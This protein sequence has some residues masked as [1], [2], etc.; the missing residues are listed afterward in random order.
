MNLCGGIQANSEYGF[1][2]NVVVSRSEVPMGSICHA[3][4][5][6]LMNRGVSCVRGL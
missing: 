1:T 2:L 6:G 5:P 4:H 3:V